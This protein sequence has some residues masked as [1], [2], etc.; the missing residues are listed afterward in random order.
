M[1]NS[2]L[3]GVHIRSWEKGGRAEAHY[4]PVIG[5]TELLVWQP[6]GS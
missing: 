3:D 5:L 1:S 4:P 6:E 2:K